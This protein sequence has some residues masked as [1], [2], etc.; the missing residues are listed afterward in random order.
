METLFISIAYYKLA[1]F[2]LLAN[3]RFQRAA[4]STPAAAG[5]SCVSAVEGIAAAA[6][7][8]FKNVLKG[9]K[10]A[11]LKGIKINALKCSFYS[12]NKSPK[13]SGACVVMW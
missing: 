4:V 8:E 12:K 7:L 11:D 2:G 13:L 10:V 5:K 3:L 6:N 9:Y 1:P